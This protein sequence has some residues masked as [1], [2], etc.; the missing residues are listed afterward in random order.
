MHKE[1]HIV[2]VS[3]VPDGQGGVTQ[4]RTSYVTQFVKMVHKSG[5][6]SVEGLQLGQDNSF[7]CQMIL[8]VTGIPNQTD[9]LSVDGV[10]YAISNAYIDD[11]QRVKQLKF[12]A[13]LRT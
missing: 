3:D 12:T 5:S 2:F 11:S 13:T 9:L 6:R 10:Y 1:G 7:S 8:P 4:T